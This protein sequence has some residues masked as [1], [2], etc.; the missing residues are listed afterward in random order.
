MTYNPMICQSHIGNL[1]LKT[2]NSKLITQNLELKTQNLEPEI[3][4]FPAE[5][6]CGTEK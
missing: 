4:I 6:S 5:K 2:Y 3:V 1:K